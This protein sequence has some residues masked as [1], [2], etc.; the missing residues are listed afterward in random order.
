MSPTLV[1]ISIT[2]GLALA[3]VAGDYFLKVAS[4]SASPFANWNFYAGLFIYG[5]SAF[6]WVA[7]MPWIIGFAGVPVLTWGAVA[8]GLLLMLLSG[9][10]L[11]E[12]AN[13]QH[14]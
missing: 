9:L 5:L 11:R 4:A 2:V 14:V 3:A 8:A 1:A 7:V 6:G 10:T 13:G 12:A